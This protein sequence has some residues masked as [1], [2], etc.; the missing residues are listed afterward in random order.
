MRQRI[1]EVHPEFS[2]FIKKIELAGGR[3]LIQG[4][5]TR[6]ILD[7]IFDAY[8]LTK[9]Y[10]PPNVLNLF[11]SKDDSGFRESVYRDLFSSANYHLVDFWEDRFIQDGKTLPN[12]YTLPF[13]DG[14]FDMVIT[15]KVI[16]E[17]IS[18]PYETLKEIFRVLKY[19]GE[20]FLIAPFV[21][22]VHQ[23]PYDFFRY[24][25]Y[26]LQHLFQKVG[27]KII[28]I[29]PTTSGFITTLDA[30]LLFNVFGIF[31]GRVQRCLNLLARK[32]LPPI[33][34]F[35]DRYIDDRG[36]FTKYYICR[37]QK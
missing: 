12:S 8:L 11:A 13:A 5:A 1:S 21:T 37:V 22:M 31:P 18:E 4:H 29:K 24:S 9:R 30:S 26:G 20:A 6:A 33:A 3:R 10:P 2:L 25:K 14:T 28:Y 16:L 17:H 36:R 32:I 15:T 7:M 19:G 35:L 23:Q 27:F 34:G